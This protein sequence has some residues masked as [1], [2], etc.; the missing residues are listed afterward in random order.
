MCI[1]ILSSNAA[2]LEIV[3]RASSLHG[4]SHFRRWTSCHC[5]I[6]L[7]KDGRFYYCV[8]ATGVSLKVTEREPSS[9]HILMPADETLGFRAIETRTDR[10]DH[11]AVHRN[12]P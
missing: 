10:Q 7:A 4:S 12:R 2:F 11:I 5:S 8:S 9:F 3:T 1:K 6:P